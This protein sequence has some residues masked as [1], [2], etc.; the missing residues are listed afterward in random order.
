MKH[1]ILLT[2]VALCLVFASAVSASYPLPCLLP[3]PT[4]KE[5]PLCDWRVQGSYPLKYYT[6]L[7]LRT[8]HE[9]ITR[10]VISVHGRRA[11]EGDDRPYDYYDHILRAARERGQESNTLIIAPYFS[12]S[13][14]K[15]FDP[16][17]QTL[18]TVDNPRCGGNPSY[19][20]IVSD[21]RLCWDAWDNNAANDYPYG[22]NAA[23]D[24]NYPD[25]SSFAIMDDIIEWLA[26]SG[27]F[28]N[29]Q[30]IIVTGQS[31]G[32]QFAIRYALAGAAEPEGITVRYVPTNPGSVPYLNPFRPTQGSKDKFPNILYREDCNSDGVI[33]GA[34]VSAP[35]SPSARVGTLFPDLDAWSVQETLLAI[36]GGF[37]WEGDACYEDGS[38]DR[39]PWGIS[40]ISS[41]NDYLAANVASTSQA[42]AQYIRRNVVLLYGIEDNVF[43]ATDFPCEGSSVWNCPHATQGD[44]RVEI[45][46]FFFNSVCLYDCSKHGFATVAADRDGDGDLDPIAHG[47][48]WMY[49]SEATRSILFDDIKPPSIKGQKYVIPAVPDHETLV[50]LQHLI[51]DTFP[52]GSR[53]VVE[54]GDD[55]LYRYPRSKVLNTFLLRPDHEFTGELTVPVRVLTPIPNAPLHGHFTS[56]RYFLRFT[57]PG[58]IPDIKVNREDGPVT[59]QQTDSLTLSLSLQNNGLTDFSDWWLA[60]AT[61]S[62]IYFWSPLTGW[63][64]SWLPAYSGRLF[65]LNTFIGY[66]I[67]LR[68]FPLGTYTFYFGVDMDMDGAINV[69]SLFVD[70]AILNLT[71]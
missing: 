52:E 13:R 63:T 62:G 41:A 33:S 67:M 31:A 24:R 51:P 53:F 45:G 57:V 26:T 36:P 28:P 7:N 9:A 18:T 3:P 8:R 22:G 10:A 40:D 43:I 16:A 11:R 30:T 59:L 4:S 2:P 12:R 61:P 14:T 29:L 64:S 35:P 71:K 68:G 47:G 25:T 46:T 34:E 42:R 37:E 58:I 44:S 17:S 23:N 21:D 15:E 49:R 32:G 54:P 20:G 39:W 19:A 50:T 6:N 5:S 69:Q 65:P 55:Y 38:Y 1:W 66:P 56:N 27:N 70:S 48:R 60:S